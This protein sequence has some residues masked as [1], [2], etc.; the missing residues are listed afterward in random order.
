M[1]SLF[2]KECLIVVFAIYDEF[3]KSWI[4]T[5]D[6]TWGTDGDRGSHT[7]TSPPTH[8]NNWPDAKTHMSDLAKAWVDDRA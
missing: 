7:I 5:A 2:Y 6:I 1:A 4:P 3:T 8:L